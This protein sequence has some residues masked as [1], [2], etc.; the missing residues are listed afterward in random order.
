MMLPRPE[1]S[2]R[3]ACPVGQR[4]SKHKALY[5]YRED[6]PFE[7]L[8]TIKGANQEWTIDGEQEFLT[9]KEAAESYFLDT[10]ASPRI[11]DINS[12]LKGVWRNLAWRPTRNLTPEV[13]SEVIQILQANF[14]ASP[15]LDAEWFEQLFGI[16][17][18]RPTNEIR[19][20]Y[21]KFFNDCNAFWVMA[22]RDSGRYVKLMEAET[23]LALHQLYARVFGIRE[24][25][26]V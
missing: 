9:L 26:V 3:R 4:P 1:F 10:I 7:L 19:V 8:C 22:D 14:R 6:A 17:V 11:A 18:N 25:K 12:E 21:G 23:N 16:G 24:A 5:R 2:F 20:G 13:I 15:S